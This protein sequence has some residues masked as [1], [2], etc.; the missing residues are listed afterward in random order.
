MRYIIKIESGDRTG[1]IISLWLI[2]VMAILELLSY[3]MPSLQTAK[4]W[5]SGLRE[6]ANILLFCF[7]ASFLIYHCNPEK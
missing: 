5:I 6:G 2:T 7:T 4:Y 3:Y 1:M